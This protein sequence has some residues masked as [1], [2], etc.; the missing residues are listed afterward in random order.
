MSFSI[1]NSSLNYNSC[2]FF[3]S[4]ERE[5][6]DKKQERKFNICFFINEKDI[7]ILNIDEEKSDCAEL[8]AFSGKE[9]YYQIIKHLIPIARSLIE[10]SLKEE[11]LLSDFNYLVSKIN[12][13]ASYFDAKAISILNSF[14]ERLKARK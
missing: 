8:L 6:F 13:P 10:E 5:I 2:S 4:V 9:K 7:N 11:S 1:I 14:P 3:V 12:I